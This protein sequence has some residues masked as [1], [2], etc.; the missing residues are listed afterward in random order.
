MAFALLCFA[1]SVFLPALSVGHWL[2]RTNAS[3]AL[4]FLP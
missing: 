3:S 4:L 1:S 2:Y